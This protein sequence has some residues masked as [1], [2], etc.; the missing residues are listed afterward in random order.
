MKRL[1]ILLLD[2]EVSKRLEYIAERIERLTGIK[3]SKREL[4]EAMVE[5]AI[6]EWEEILQKRK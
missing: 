1:I 2:N 4:V 3:P 5:E 6:L